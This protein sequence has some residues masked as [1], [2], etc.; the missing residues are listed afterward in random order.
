MNSILEELYEYF[1]KKGVLEIWRIL[2]NYM[3]NCGIGT[4][5]KDLDLHIAIIHFLFNLLTHHGLHLKLSKSVFMQLQMDFL[6]V[7]I[8]KDGATVDP[9]K[10]TGLRNYPHELKDKWQVHGFLGVS[11]YHRMFCPNFSIIATPLTKLTGKDV[12]FEWGPQQKEAQN[13]LIDMNTHAPVLVWPDPDQQFELETDA[14]QVGTGA[15]LYQRD[16]PITKP[17]GTQKPGP[18]QPVGFHS[19]K[20][21]QTEQN[22]PIYDWEFLGVMCGLHC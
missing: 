2:Q 17:D 7:W 10:V 13:K 6:G 8:S 12:P 3:D 20:F 18:R 5:L 22:Y 15:I 21:T 4:L 19:Q 11:G 14:S 9:A 16:P 1:E